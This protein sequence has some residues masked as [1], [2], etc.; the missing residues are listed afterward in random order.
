MNRPLVILGIALAFSVAL[1]S[2]TTPAK[3]FE[4][5]DGCRLIPNNWN[6]GDSFHVRI[7]DGREIVARLYFIDAPEA[8][9]AY[10]DRIAEQAQYCAGCM[11]ARIKSWM[12]ERKNDC[13]RLTASSFR[14]PF[15]SN[16]FPLKYRRHLLLTRRVRAIHRCS[17]AKA[18]RFYQKRP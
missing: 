13:P 15:S 12:I 16:S 8:E 7:A 11:N 14:L 5:L 6:D 18:G 4:R 9:T 17:P 2:A 10:R 3:P 1:C